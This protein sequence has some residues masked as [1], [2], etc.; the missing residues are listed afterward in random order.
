MISS[1]KPADHQYPRC[2]IRRRTTQVSRALQLSITR[3]AS[4][5]KL[6]IRIITGPEAP[7][8]S[9]TK[10]PH[11]KDKIERKSRAIDK[12]LGFDEVTAENADEWLD[13]RM[14]RI[15]QENRERSEASWTQLQ[16]GLD[17]Q[18]KMS[19][20][21]LP[22]SKE[23]PPPHDSSAAKSSRQA[24]TKATAPRALPEQNVEDYLPG[25]P[26]S[27]LPEEFPESSVRG[28]VVPVGDMNNTKKATP[29]AEYEPLQ[30][31]P[32]PAKPQKRRPTES[33]YPEK[34]QKRRPPMMPSPNTQ[35]SNGKDEDDDE[36][37]EY[38]IDED[39]REGNPDAAGIQSAYRR[40]QQTTKK[41]RHFSSRTETEENLSK[42][43][44][45]KDQQSQSRKRPRANPLE[46]NLGPNW[47]FHL[48]DGSRPT[49]ARGSG[50]TW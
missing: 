47:D 11:W 12:E 46:T 23:T 1:P 19:R 15:A 43:E 28:P 26:K 17:F 6:T 20:G 21:V 50:H 34:Q 25:N 7:T 27:I 3:W 38:D 4:S 48:V 16:A 44:D 2:L 37:C 32:S 39:Y 45:P 31:Y 5:R 29:P 13:S 41:R 33:L 30:A 36:D 14:N 9:K 22:C 18:R 42:E 10:A 24:T 35:T 49:K 8:S 40:R